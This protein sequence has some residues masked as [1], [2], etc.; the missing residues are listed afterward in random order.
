MDQKEL[1]IDK[2][3]VVSVCDF[4][5]KERGEKCGKIFQRSGNFERHVNEVHKKIRQ[6]CECG[7]TMTQSAL[8]RHKKESCRLRKRHQ[9][10]TNPTPS[11]EINGDHEV[12]EVKK[13]RIETDVQ[14]ITMK[15]GALILV[16]DDIKLGEFTFKLRPVDGNGKLMAHLC[17]M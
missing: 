9:T 4:F 7:S 6:T 16:Q 5:I 14:L 13:F 2:K 15:N 1:N 3:D 12:V 11:I 17:I 8:I 10:K